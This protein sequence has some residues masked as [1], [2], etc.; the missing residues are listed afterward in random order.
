MNSILIITA[1]RVHVLVISGILPVNISIYWREKNQQSLR[2]TSCYFI[3]PVL[4]NNKK[5]HTYGMCVCVCVCVC[6]FVCVF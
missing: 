1:Y 6:V 4:N 2:R 5:A 3:W